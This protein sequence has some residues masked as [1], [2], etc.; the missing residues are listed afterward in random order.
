MKRE[1]LNWKATQAGNM[2]TSMRARRN[3]PFYTFTYMC[4]KKTGNK[5]TRVLSTGNIDKTW[6]ICKMPI[7]LLI[8]SL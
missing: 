6:Q 8:A 3:N 4:L 2:Y 1:K 7:M 5:H